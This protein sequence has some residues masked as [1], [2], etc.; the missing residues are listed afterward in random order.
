MILKSWDNR[1]YH[2]WRVGFPIPRN[3]W[4]PFKF[5]IQEWVF[6]HEPDFEVGKIGILYYYDGAMVIRIIGHP[7][8][9]DRSAWQV[10]ALGPWVRLPDP[11]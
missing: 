9:N 3:R 1:P 7:S 4:Y 10:E 6:E 11:F 5:F 2:V 8:E